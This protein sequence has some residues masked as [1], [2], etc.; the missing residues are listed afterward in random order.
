MFNVFLSLLLVTFLVGCT[1]RSRK[2][3]VVDISEVAR[4]V[5]KGKKE[6]TNFID[7]V[8]RRKQLKKDIEDY[9]KWLEK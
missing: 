4:K 6:K 9:K 7:A 5:R 1:E 2:Y 8:N 3:K